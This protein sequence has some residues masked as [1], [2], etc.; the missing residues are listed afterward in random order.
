M[1]LV[2]CYEGTWTV[3]ML[4]IIIVEDNS[5][6]T[7]KGIVLCL[8]HVQ[9]RSDP[10]YLPAG[11]P[12]VVQQLRICL[13]CRSHRRCRFNGKIPWRRA[14]QPTPGFFPGE[15]HG[16]PGRLQSIGLQSRTQLKRL[17]THAHLL[18]ALLVSTYQCS[19]SVSS[20]VLE[21]P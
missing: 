20:P 4:R 18:I 5:T 11:P 9:R 15:S 2:D 3:H 13:Q 16:Q 19:V 21:M 1:F 7:R 12:P 6:G 14:W 10:L 17:S 8:P